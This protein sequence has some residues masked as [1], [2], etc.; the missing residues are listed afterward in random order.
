ML[1]ISKLEALGERRPPWPR[2][3]LIPILFTL[4]ML[5][6]ADER[7]TLK[8]LD[9]Y[10]YHDLVMLPLLWR[11]FA[12]LLILE[13]VDHHHNFISYLLYYTGPRH[14]ISSQS[15]HNVC[16]NAIQKQTDKQ[17][18]QKNITSFAK[19]VT[20]IVLLQPNLHSSDC[21]DILN[22]LLMIS[23]GNQFNIYGRFT[24]HDMFMCI[25]SWIGIVDGSKV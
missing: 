7:L 10:L 11:C 13:Y 24:V 21:R 5:S 4:K 6:L 9:H 18:L 12:H 22:L 17:T 1:K 15:I 16:S 2:Q 8:V 20:T 25:L 23:Y 3:I 19:E 14:K